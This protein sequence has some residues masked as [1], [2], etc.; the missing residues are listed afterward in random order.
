MC[1]LYINMVKS[2]R[3]TDKGTAIIFQLSRGLTNAEIS[4]TLGVCESL[5]RYY[6]KKQ[7]NLEKKIEEIKRDLARKAARKLKKYIK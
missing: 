3:R 1:D 6:R 7:E 4:N 5:V 2:Y